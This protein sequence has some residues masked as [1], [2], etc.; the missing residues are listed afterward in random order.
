MSTLSDLNNTYTHLDETTRA[1]LAELT[2]VRIELM[3]HQIKAKEYLLQVLANPTP[4]NE[5]QLEDFDSTVIAPLRARINELAQPLVQQS[6]NLQGIVGMLPM[7]LAGLMQYIDPS[8]LFAAL[9]IDP[10]E[11]EEKIKQL[12]QLISI[13]FGSDDDSEPGSLG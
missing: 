6:L 10:G 2:R 4:D 8:L 1:Q 9:G 11:A 7:M 5:Q 13:D 12:R 3:G